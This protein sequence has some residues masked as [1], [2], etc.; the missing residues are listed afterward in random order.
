MW[1]ALIK[2]ILNYND[3]TLARISKESGVSEMTI[4]RLLRGGTSEPR[5]STGSRLLALYL[6]IQ[7][8]QQTI[9][10]AFLNSSK[11]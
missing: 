2:E 11:S 6:K 3:Y 8:E 5:Y 4:R 9:Y 1:Q 7:H 10:E